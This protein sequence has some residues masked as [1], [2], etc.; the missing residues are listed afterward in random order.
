MIFFLSFWQ[1]NLTK[2]NKSIN[3]LFKSLKMNIQNYERLLYRNDGAKKWFITPWAGLVIQNISNNG[4]L[5]KYSS[6][7]ELKKKCTPIWISLKLL[8]FR[9]NNVFLHYSNVMSVTV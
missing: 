1:L 7:H 5:V 2:C 8:L 9:E 4:N 6:L 3:G